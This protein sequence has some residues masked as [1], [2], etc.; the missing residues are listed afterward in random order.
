MK[1][2][3]DNWVKDVARVR[4]TWIR[5]QE[6]REHIEALQLSGEPTAGPMAIIHMRVPPI[7]V[8]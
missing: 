3:V 7:D 5:A 8:L 4:D 2:R 6:I 1:Y